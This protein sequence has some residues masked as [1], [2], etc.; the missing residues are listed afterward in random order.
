[1]TLGTVCGGIR[2]SLGVV[3]RA[4]NAELGR[5]LQAILGR[6]EACFVRSIGLDCAAGGL[7]SSQAEKSD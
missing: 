1:M 2:L 3:E 7:Y 6:V 5:M 4:L